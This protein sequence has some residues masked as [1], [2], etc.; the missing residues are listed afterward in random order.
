MNRALK[1]KT[2][3]AQKGAIAAKVPPAPAQN[4]MNYDG[5]SNLAK[6][7]FEIQATRGTSAEGQTVSWL[8]LED[9]K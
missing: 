7:N 4:I 9:T 6:G 5:R 1:N 8:G 2:R 3:G